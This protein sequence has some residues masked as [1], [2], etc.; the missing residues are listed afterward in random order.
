MH[1]PF[2]KNQGGAVDT[3]VLSQF[4]VI[5]DQMKF[6]NIGVTRQVPSNPTVTSTR[7]FKYLI[8]ADCDRGPV[9]ITYLDTPNVF[10]IA[11]QRVAYK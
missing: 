2:K 5:H 3:E 11:H 8:C 10:Y 7:E 6:E 4:W 9:G 1:V